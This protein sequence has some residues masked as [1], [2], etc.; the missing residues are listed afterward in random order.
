MRSRHRLQIR[1]HDHP[2][3][4]LYDLQRE[5]DLRMDQVYRFPSSRQHAAVPSGRVP[6]C[7]VLD[8]L[9]RQRWTAE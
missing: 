4:R 3:R 7:L 1:R 6:L 9:V 5:P 2:T 8:P